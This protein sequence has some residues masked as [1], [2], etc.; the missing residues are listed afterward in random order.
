[1]NQFFGPVVY[2]E[3]SSLETKLENL[4]RNPFADKNDI[5]MLE[6]GIQGEKQVEY[7]LTKSNIGMYIMRDINLEIDGFTAQIDFVVVTSHHCYFIESKNYSAG[8]IHIDENRNFELS[9]KYGRMYRRRGIKSPISQVDDQLNVF[10]K[11][12]IK[13]RENAEK[14]FSGLKFSEYMKTMVVFTNLQNRINNKRA[15]YDIKYRVLKVD[16]LVRQ[17]EYDEKHYKGTKLS[18]EQML[19]ITNYILSNNK[20]IEIEKVQPIVEYIDAISNTANKKTILIDL[21]L[22]ILCIIVALCILNWYTKGHDESLSKK[23]LNGLNKDT[24]TLSKENILAINNLKEAYNNS[25]EFG[26]DLYRYEECMNLKLPNYSICTGDPIKVDFPDEDTLKICKSS[27]C[28]YTK[29]DLNNKNVLNVYSNP[30]S[31]FPNTEIGLIYYDSSDKFLEKIGGYSKILE[32]ARVAH[33]QTSGFEDYFD[34]S[35]ISERGG[36]PALSSTYKETVEKYFRTLV[37]K[38]GYT[39]NTLDDF[40]KMVEYY[41]YI[42]R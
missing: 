12:C 21:I 15:P 11:I 4:K 3:S 10:Q 41:Y 14:T 5:Y 22:G 25:Q 20:E 37:G 36:N 42:M 27:I 26:F 32:I 19:Q 29:Y 38:G 17:I 2:K 34:F 13:D 35:H 6:T 18:Q 7:Y 30:S 28:Y 9:T 24:N 16:N 39:V 8:I 23:S 31:S 40:K 1:M 33:N